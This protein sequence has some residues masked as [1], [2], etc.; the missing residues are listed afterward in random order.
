MR[1]SEYSNIDSFLDA[2]IQMHAKSPHRSEDVD[3]TFFGAVAREAIPGLVLEFGVATGYTFNCIA[4]SFPDQ[5]V[6]GFDWFQGLPE[7]WRADHLKGHFACDVP[8][9]RD[10]AEL[11]I[12][13]FDDTLPKFMQE[14][15]GPAV[16]FV[17]L[18]ADL[19]SST[20]TILNN[21]ESRVVKGTILLF[22]ELEYPGDYK[23][24][25]YKAFREFLERTGHDCEYFGTRGRETVAFRIV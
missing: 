2:A 24:H 3:R 5:T 1:L 22:D 12:G 17:H 8:A 13:L 15:Q 7:D 14:H 10:N 19:Y 18:D 6:Y 21:I 11:I 23:D 20:V 9:V 4:D 16:S 25:E